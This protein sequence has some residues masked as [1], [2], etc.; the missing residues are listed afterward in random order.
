MENQ[1]VYI[2]IITIKICGHQIIE[3]HYLRNHETMKKNGH[4]QF[5]VPLHSFIAMAGVDLLP[6]FVASMTY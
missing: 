3:K 4:Y 2:Y 5:G 6:V 1:H